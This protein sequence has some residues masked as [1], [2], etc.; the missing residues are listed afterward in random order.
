MKLST[1]ALA[2]AVAGLA[3]SGCGRTSGSI[4]ESASTE[5]LR[6]VEVTPKLMTAL[7]P[8]VDTET[9]TLDFELDGKAELIAALE[10]KSYSCK[11]AEDVA[12]RDC[13]A[14][15]YELTGLEDAKA[16]SLTV[17]ANLTDKETKE[18]V[19]SQDLVINFAVDLPGGAVL[20]P[21]QIPTTDPARTSVLSTRL[22]LG[23]TYVVEVPESFHVTEYWNQLSYGGSSW[24]RVLPDSDPYYLG[25]GD[26]SCS[27]TQDATVEAQNSSGRWYRYCKTA[28]QPR[29]FDLPYHGIEAYIELATDAEEVT[30]TNHERFFLSTYDQSIS[31]GDGYDVLR[32]HDE[33][34]Y[35]LE[36]PS[37]L[38]KFAQVCQ[39][40]DVNFIDAPM[41]NNFFLGRAAET[42]RFWYCDAVL[43]DP[44]GS[45]SAWKIGA[46][47]ERDQPDAYCSACNASAKT[48]EA[49][50]MLRPSEFTYLPAYFA[51]KAQERIGFM[52]T[53]VL[54]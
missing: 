36:V 53:K 31:T 13:S 48:I 42:V 5:A 27:A 33:N 32:M 37:G 18:E 38:R 35:L 40:K 41:V 7:A 39:G 19:A 50:Y 16:Y 30:S 26:R 12:F 44:N 25:G 3:L 22:Q 9:L 17:H 29:D 46:F 28:A 10:F 11:L 49:V 23:A 14:K 20:D 47:V 8:V 21:N 24:Y 4:V 34:G 54:P 6:T 2:T 45:P 1:K 52:L 51:R 43:P 15:P